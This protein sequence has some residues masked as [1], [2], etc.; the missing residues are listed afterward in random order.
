MTHELQAKCFC[1]KK[2]F[3]MTNLGTGVFTAKCPVN[4]TKVIS[5]KSS[6]LE[7][8]GKKPCGYVYTKQI[9]PSAENL[10][11]GLNNLSLDTLALDT[12]A[13]KKVIEGLNGNVLNRNIFIYDILKYKEESSGSESEHFIEK[14]N[15]K[16]ELVDKQL[17]ESLRVKIMSLRAFPDYTTIYEIIW[18]LNEYTEN[19][20]TW[21]IKTKDDIKKFYKDIRKIYTD[22]KLTGFT[23][24]CPYPRHF[25]IVDKIIVKDKKEIVQQV[26][27]TATDPLLIPLVHPNEFEN[28]ITDNNN[29]NNMSTEE[30]FSDAEDSESDGGFAPDPK[31]RYNEGEDD[32]VDKDADEEEVEEEIEEEIVIDADADND[33]DDICEVVDDVGIEIDSESDNESDFSD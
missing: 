19:K 28:F 27:C 22:L 3:C 18:A 31:E 1:G 10:D 29:N 20:I 12:L 2:P 7:K 6:K 23:Y 9:Y 33:D 26:E 32:E 16:L 21:D 5:F 13:K 4:T 11:F 30:M 15:K 25:N 24:K 17:L 14:C 8:T